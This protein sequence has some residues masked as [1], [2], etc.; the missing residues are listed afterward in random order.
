MLSESVEFQVPGGYHAHRTYR[1]FWFWL[2]QLPQSPNM[3][4]RSNVRPRCADHDGETELASVVVLVA[5]RAYST[6]FFGGVR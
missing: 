6:F 5:Y 3:P 4:K 1:I 2:M